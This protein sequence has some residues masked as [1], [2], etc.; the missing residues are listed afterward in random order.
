MDS[1]KVAFMVIS[2][3][4][5][6]QFVTSVE[7]KTITLNLANRVLYSYKANQ[8]EHQIKSTRIYSSQLG[9]NKIINQFFSVS[10]NKKDIVLSNEFQSRVS[11]C[12]SLKQCDNELSSIHKCV[13]SMNVIFYSSS[14]E[15]QQ[16]QIQTSTRY[17]NKIKSVKLNLVLSDFTNDFLR[18][19]Q[20]FYT[21]KLTSKTLLTTTD[22]F[23][24][25]GFISA[26]MTMNSEF[27]TNIK[28][29]LD[30]K[31]ENKAEF[32]D[33]FEMNAGTGLLKLNKK[34]FLSESN[35][36][37]RKFEFYVDAQS[38]CSTEGPLRNRTT[39]TLSVLNLNQTQFQV[40]NLIDVKRLSSTY[41]CVK[42]T[43]KELVANKMIAL[44]QVI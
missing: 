6:L 21:F 16:R 15:S 40:T 4:L 33:L 30:F 35:N 10:Q 13:M 1:L 7:Q 9:N 37:N 31:S 11:L 22:D 18:F 24:S 12:S 26:F 36:F 23:V 17:I 32:I 39:I 29:Y 34:Q 3:A 41:E 43:R 8:T 25:L 20:D 19:A 44:A 28:Y 5:A 42:L 27:N 38:Q 14:I 2:L